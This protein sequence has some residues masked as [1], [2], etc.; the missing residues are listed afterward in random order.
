MLSRP[1]T[2]S[3]SSGRPLRLAGPEALILNPLPSAVAANYIVILLQ[4]CRRCSQLLFVGP[5]ASRLSSVD[6][7]DFLARKDLADFLLEALLDF[8]AYGFAHSVCN[9][10][11]YLKGRD[12]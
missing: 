9:I 10:F 1:T 2:L 11:S 8:L 12:Q 7:A 4:F 3:G 6:L 5:T